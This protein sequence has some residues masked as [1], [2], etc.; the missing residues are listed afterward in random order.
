[1]ALV[2]ILRRICDMAFQ[3]GSLD[4]KNTP[5]IQLPA[6]DEPDSALS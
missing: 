1:V 6:L 5:S 4:T 2:V 3:R